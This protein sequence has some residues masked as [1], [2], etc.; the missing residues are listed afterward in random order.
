M[1]S[2][3]PSVTGLSTKQITFLKNLKNTHLNSEELTFLFLHGPP[4]NPKK[5]IS[6]LKRVGKMIS[7]DKFLTEISQ[8]KESLFQ[9][10]GLTK[11][12]ARIDEDFNLQFGTISS[13]WEE[14]IDFCKNHVILTLS[15]HTH[16]LKEFRLGSMRGNGKE[17]T[18]SK[19]ESHHIP[20]YYDLYSEIYTNSK[21]IEDNGPFIVQTPALGLGG[22]NNPKLMG[23]FRE[24]HVKDGKLD[25][26]KVK[27]INR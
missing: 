21:D 7:S 19:E 4:I 25:S 11:S 1:I 27:F 13:H 5:S 9:K 17:K 10:L 26:F 14:L 3:K 12:T 2:G 18:E 6:L 15:G 22:Y 20:I 8:F 16:E 23:G 24:I